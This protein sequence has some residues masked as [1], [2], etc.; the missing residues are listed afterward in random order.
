MELIVLYLH[1]K[2][3]KI[4]IRV[5][6][7]KN[8]SALMKSPTPPPQRKRQS[9]PHKIMHILSHVFKYPFIIMNFNRENLAVGLSRSAKWALFIEFP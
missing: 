1:Q 4:P 5:V 8:I 3:E 9:Q 6:G 2:S 7:L